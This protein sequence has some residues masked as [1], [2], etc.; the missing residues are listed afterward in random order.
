MIR[1]DPAWGSRLAFALAEVLMSQTELALRVNVS[2]ATVSRWCHGELPR[3][4]LDVVPVLSRVLGVPV[5][6]LIPGLDTAG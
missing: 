4:G 3:D 6:K 5:R 2:R 1:R